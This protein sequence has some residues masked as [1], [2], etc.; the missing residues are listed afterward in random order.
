M[1]A[2]QTASERG[3][4]LWYLQIS[5][6]N[7]NLTELL[8]L[9]LAF[10][11]E[12]GEADWLI[13]AVCFDDLRERTVRPDMLVPIRDSLER[14]SALGGDGVTNLV[15][16]AVRLPDAASRLTREAVERSAIAGTPQDRLERTLT[17]FLERR[18]RAY[19]NRGKIRAALEVWFRQW[20]LSL[21]VGGR[22]LT[23]EVPGDTTRWNWAGME[24]L[25]RLARA[26]RARVLLYE[27]PYRPGE[28]CFI[29]DRQAYERFFESLRGWCR[30]EGVL[31]ADL[32]GIVPAGVFGFL[33]DGRPDVFH[34]TGEGHRR[35]GEAV[36]R[37]LEGASK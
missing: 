18:W 10:I 33:D 27:Q 11:Q 36:D 31:L 23:V 12:G 9:Y 28:E 25:V 29:H 34:F 16:E 4:G 2:N 1:H 19:E 8:A 20:F 13:V 15:R 7:A 37:V 17:T 32:G 3:G 5:E 14:Y 24:A 22:P 26:R 21:A 6:A 35:L 30:R